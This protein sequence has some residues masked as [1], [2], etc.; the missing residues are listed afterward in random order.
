M[1]EE[2][3]LF[4][5]REY[6]DP[7]PLGYVTNGEQIKGATIPFHE[8]KNYIG[9]KVLLEMPRESAIDYKVIKVIEFFENHEKVYK[10]EN[11]VAVQ[12]GTCSV[13][14]FTD[15]AKHKF[16]NSWLS[17]LYCKNGRI[18]THYSHPECVYELRR[19]K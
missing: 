3:T 15:K 2:L 14:R 1:T 19:T 18:K 4:N 10:W 9:K 17:E 8:L 16:G 7:F 5:W 6:E 12:T 11:G 13:I